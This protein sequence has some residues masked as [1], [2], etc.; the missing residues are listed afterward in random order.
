MKTL[1]VQSLKL[2]LI[3]QMLVILMPVTLLLAYQAW[4]DLRR[5]ER[6]D[7]A[8]QL[9]ALAKD[10]YDSYHRFVIGVS[11]AVDTGRVA[12]PALAALD[13]ARHKLAQLAVADPQGEVAS[14]DRELD[15]V[16]QSLAEDASIAHA[17]ALRATISSVDRQL[18]RAVQHYD[19]DAHSTIVASIATARTQHDVVM[20][21]A[22]F[23]LLAA[24]FFVYGMIKGLT[25]PLG[26]AVK[27]AQRIARGDL[28]PQPPADVRHDLDG[29][30]GSL[31]AMEHKLFESRQQVEQRTVEL[32]AVTAQA[33]SLAQEAEAA[34]R[35]KSQF[36][37]NMSHEIRTPMNG[38]LGMTELLLGTPLTDKQRRFAQAVYRSGESLLEIINDI[39]DFSKIEAG[40]FELDR[41]DFNLRTVLEDA[42]ELLAPRAHEKR[43]EL[44]CHIDAEVPAAIVGDPGRVRQ[45]V[46]NL[47]GNAIKFTQ[48]GEVA[49]HVVRRPAGSET[50]GDGLLEFSVRDSGI[51]MDRDTMAKLFNAFTQANGSMARRYGGT[52]LGLAITKQLVEMM[53]G[54]LQVDSAPGAGSTFCFS[55]PF[56]VGTAM[57]ESASPA[58]PAT[59]R[60]RR[61][62]VVDDNPTNAAVVEAHLRAWGMRVAVSAHGG[63]ALAWLRA[64]HA[65]GESVDVA[66]IDMKMPVM[67]GIA[68][69]EHLRDE[70]QLAP[71]RL[72]M[73][74]SVATDEDARRARARGVDLYVAKPVRQQELLRAILQAADTGPAGSGETAAL[75]ARVLVAEDNLVNQEVIKAMLEGLGCETTVA[76]SGTD[77]LVTLTRAEFDMVFMD[78]QMPEMDGFEAVAH[79]RAG[80]S[81]RFPFVNTRGLPIVALTANALVGDAERCLAAGFDDYVSKPFTQRQIETLVRR[82]ALRDGN[83]DTAPQ[84]LES[85]ARSDR[86]AQ[87]VLDNDA[88][89]ELRRIESESGGGLLDKV[90]ATYSASS[91]TLVSSLVSALDEH[92]ADAA[93]MAAHSLKSSS[94][95]VGAFTL[96]SL[97]DTIETLALSRRLN[98][99]QRHVDELERQHAQVGAAIEALRAGEAASP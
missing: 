96:S 88:V 45:I 78:C 59:L 77:A 58:D 19:G 11:D 13:T 94:A 35:A 4:S 31:S 8:F 5:A 24:V 55:I 46:T 32:R 83:A 29:L 41:V 80:A 28:L 62:L 89:Q 98:E 20:A 63:E 43:L 37:A 56:V 67:D 23:T 75:G 87:Q 82:W 69:A 25:E 85:E 60:G 33:Q 84:A 99:A 61:A 54:R 42:F 52:G 16:S 7:R 64:A 71:S 81:E 57:P 9:D 6:V 12:R 47:V 34:N 49:M 66:L 79:F 53:G 76:A 2:R 15:P 38:I 18:E 95:N 65:R 72:V 68:L 17:F 21:A 36:L 51:G 22:L 93:A 10:A 97:C 74:T 26:R 70:P 27:T 90:L 50:P 14:L 44:I 3:L 91:G 30:L 92:D 1:H 73:L 86:R 40:K 39:L 48:R